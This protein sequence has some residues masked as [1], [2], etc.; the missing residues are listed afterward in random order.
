MRPGE[1]GTGRGLGTRLGEPGTGRGLGTRLGGPGTGRGLGTRLGEPGTGRGLG[2]R[3]GEPGTG[4]GLGTRLG[5]P[6]T[7]RGLGTRL[8]EPG[9]GRGLG[10]RL[11]EPGTGRGLGTRLGGPGT[12]RGLGTRPGEPGTGKGL[13]TRLG[14][15]GTGRGLG[16]RPGEPGTGRG[17]GTRPGEPGTGRGLGTTNIMDDSFYHHEDSQLLDGGEDDLLLQ[18]PSSTPVKEK[19]ADDRMETE[20]AEP[21]M[22]MD[23]EVL[24]PDGKLLKLRKDY[25]RTSV[26]LIKAKAHLGFISSCKSQEKTPRGLKINVK[27]SAFLADHT[28]ILD[29]FTKTTN[30]AEKDY[31]SDLDSHYK[32]IVTQLAQKQALLVKTMKT[33]ETQAS[34]E[35]KEAHQNMLLKTK[36]NVQKL[37]SDIE[38]KKK[39]KLDHISQPYQKR[40]RVDK[41]ASRGDIGDQWRMGQGRPRKENTTPV[42]NDQ[43]WSP[44]P[45]PTHTPQ[46]MQPPNLMSMTLSE[47]LLSIQNQTQPRGVATQCTPESGQAPSLIHPGGKG[48]RG[49]PPQP[50]LSLQHVGSQMQHMSTLYDSPAQRQPQ[51]LIQ[52]GG[53]GGPTRGL[54]G[55]QTPGR[56]PLLQQPTR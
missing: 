5:E 15:P 55:F 20:P 13:G 31:V 16:T 48:G 34:N 2:T 54:Q 56:L 4:R 38:K 28:N 41:P 9:T 43:I 46:T 22:P 35:E 30:A 39:R 12:G 1:P 29:Q 19:G 24:G 27:C 21:A 51:Q 42:V 49:R 11:G 45:A 7:G 3:L 6:G 40:R 36:T 17:L 8:K 53:R 37:S 44:Y 23:E 32:K 52:A 10:T 18:S 50:S 47:L 26:S 33:V 14:E 25:K